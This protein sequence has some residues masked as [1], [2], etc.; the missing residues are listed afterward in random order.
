MDV[1]G[2]WLT[3]EHQGPF[4]VIFGVMEGK[5]VAGLVE[6]VERWVTRVTLVAPQYPRR[7]NPEA[8]ERMFSMDAVRIIPCVRDA[9]IAADESRVTV[10]CGSGFLAG[11]ARAVL[12][13][14]DY[15]ECGLLTRAR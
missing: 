12:L 14:L 1:F 3:T 5:D 15:P 10:I 7:L 8:I 6:G 2:Q 9:I 11:E 4:D 13:D